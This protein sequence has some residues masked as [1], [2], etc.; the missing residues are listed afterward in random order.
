MRYSGLTDEA[1][2]Y[3]KRKLLHNEIRPGERIREDYIAAELEMSRTPVREAINRLVTEGF[4]ISEQRKGLFAAEITYEELVR[5]LDVRVVLETLAVTLC[6]ENITPGQC[7]TL[8][9]ILGEYESAL[10][11]KRFF[12]S[13][14]LDARI[15][16]FIAECSQ[17]K[18]LIEYITDLQEFVA[19]ARSRSEIDWTDGRVERA[20]DDH[21]KLVD[22]II[23]KDEKEAKECVVRDIQELKKLIAN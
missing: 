17:N 18:K 1:Y 13:S 23:R 3:I 5:M 14:D 15:H 20:L 22:A 11:E 19:Y 6:C 21:R 7:E 16:K 12:D 9:H 2:A 10:K 4:V 8:Q